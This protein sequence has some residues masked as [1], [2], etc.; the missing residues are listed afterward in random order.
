MKAIIDID[1]ESLRKF[2]FMIIAK[3]SNEIKAMSDEEL[4]LA[5]LKNSVH[6]ATDI[7]IY[8]GK[9]A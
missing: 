5:C 4:V 7:Q 6:A 1:V 9:E 8:K 2:A 3:T